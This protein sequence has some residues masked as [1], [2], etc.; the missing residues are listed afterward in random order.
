M[1]FRH[2]RRNTRSNL[3]FLLMAGLCAFE[4]PISYRPQTIS[5]AFSP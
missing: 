3:C 1:C 5:C 4:Y 2:K